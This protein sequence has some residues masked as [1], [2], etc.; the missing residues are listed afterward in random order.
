MMKHLK[1]VMMAMRRDGNLTI[2]PIHLIGLSRLYTFPLRLRGAT[3]NTEIFTLVQVKHMA[4]K[5]M[6]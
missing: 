4:A 6:V 1:R 5:L 2:S 3:A